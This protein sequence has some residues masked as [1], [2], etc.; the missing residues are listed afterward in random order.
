MT[1]YQSTQSQSSHEE[2]GPSVRQLTSRPPDPSATLRDSS[3]LAGAV[4]QGVIHDT[5]SQDRALW[6]T[7]PRVTQQGLS[8]DIDAQRG[9]DYGKKFDDCSIVYRG[10][11]QLETGPSYRNTD[12]FC[13]A[14]PADYF[15]RVNSDMCAYPLN[16]SVVPSFDDRPPHRY[17]VPPWE[18]VLKCRPMLEVGLL[19]TIILC[20]LS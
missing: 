17:D 9:A 18:N 7:E 20:K 10:S 1:S 19:V 16:A 4:A 12:D 5:A 3:E 13:L 6:H 2:C 8:R 15:S 11:E 14:E